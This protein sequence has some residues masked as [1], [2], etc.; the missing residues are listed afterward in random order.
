MQLQRLN[1]TEKLLN[2]VVM[3]HLDEHLRYLI[4]RHDC[5]VVPGWGAFIT[6][7]IPARYNEA[8][9]LYEPPCR[10]VLF[11]PGLTHN[12]GLLASSVA[13]RQQISYDRAL[14]SIKREV[15][16]MHHQLSGQGE[17]AINRVGLFKYAGQG[18][19]PIFEP[20]K[21]SSANA[22][23]AFLPSVDNL[24]STTNATA[25]SSIE[26]SN[27]VKR[28]KIIPTFVRVAAAVAVF[29][30]LGFTLTIPVENTTEQTDFASVFVGNHSKTA[31]DISNDKQ[32][33]RELYIS[34]PNQL[35]ATSTV[36][37]IATNRYRKMVAKY[38]RLRERRA[39]RNK[40]AKPIEVKSVVNLSATTDKFIIV[41]ASFNSSNKAAK[42]ISQSGDSTLRISA[43]G[44]HF[45]VY[46]A[47]ADNNDEAARLRAGTAKK[48]KGA[49][50]CEL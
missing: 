33:S 36:D 5:V 13:R 7:S 6:Q 49:W 11:N 24:A 16:T 25:E 34:L 14:D 19:S 18:L 35:A 43:T 23:F 31:A 50:V 17:L 29:L 48:Y 37:T 30:A 2:F 47:S 21:V 1:N 4:S 46:S 22:P 39:A 42:F 40:E 38:D 45:R 8:T 32:D 26:T 20:A 9:C 44:G 41:V 28:H 27:V 3:L 10:E 15:E 12:D